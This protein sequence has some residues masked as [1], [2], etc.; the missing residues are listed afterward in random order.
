[1]TSL[2][3]ISNNDSAPRMGTCGYR[4]ECERI[5]QL[6]TSM[7]REGRSIIQ[8]IKAIREEHGLSISEC[9]AWVTSHEVWAKAAKAHEPLHDALESAFMDEREKI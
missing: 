5:D 1:M 9:K 8:T 4:R 6:I 3:D 7:H 2:N